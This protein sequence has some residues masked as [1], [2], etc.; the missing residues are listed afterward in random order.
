MAIV[1]MSKIKV[2]G[3]IS[4]KDRVY[5]YLQNNSIVHIAKT[6]N[7]DNTTCIDN[8]EKIS[9]MT[10]KRAKID[11]FI[12]F[13]HNETG[14]DVK[15]ITITFDQISGLDYDYNSDEVLLGGL[16]LKDKIGAIKAELDKKESTKALLLM[17]SSESLSSLVEQNVLSIDYDHDC[18]AS[19]KVAEVK[20]SIEGIKDQLE[21]LRDELMNY[22]IKSLQLK[23]EYLSSEIQKAKGDNLIKVTKNTFILEFYIPSK[24][25]NGICDKLEKLSPTIIAE[26]ERIKDDEEVP[27]LTQNNKVI[28]Q[29]EFVTNMYSVPSYHESDPNFLVFWFFMIFFGYIM[30]DIGIGLCL[31]IIGYFLASRIKEDNGSK[32]LWTLIGTG[33]IFTIFWGTLYNSFFGFAVL[34]WGAI[35]PDPQ[36]Q[37]ILT[38]LFCLLLGV[39]HIACAYFMKGLNAIKRGSVADAILDCFLWD[40]FFLGMVMALAKFLLDFFHLVDFSQGGALADFLTAIQEPGLFLL[41]ASLLIIVVFAGRKS[42]GFGKIVKGFTSLYGLISLMSDILSYARLFGLMLSGAIIGQQFDAIG[43]NLMSGGFIGILMGIIVIAIGNAF[44]LAMGALGA[45]IHDCRLQYIEY[46]GKF[47]TGEGILFS[48]FRP[49]YKYVKITNGEN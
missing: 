34:P 23:R 3:L 29:A 16:K 20:E 43:V 38:L 33:G 4:D 14:T 32:R 2:I 17:H 6:G 8:S 35:M 28:R 18:L 31:I 48:P 13:I 15:E 11:D 1:K 37:T 45:Y 26:K 24:E 42:K 12:T 27:T 22:D 41:V 39:L 47:Y 49:D 40:T 9:K 19:E 30:A 21:K 5:N 7:Y 36:Q 10:E 44:N 46:F 25:E